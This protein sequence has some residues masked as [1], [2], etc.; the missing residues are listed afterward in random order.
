MKRILLD[1]YRRWWWMMA[2]ASVFHL[3]S[4]FHLF[5]QGKSEVHFPAVIFMGAIL[6]SFD[7]QR[8]SPA[9]ALLSLPVTMD[10][11]GRTWWLACVGI[12]GVWVTFLSLCAY[13]VASLVGTAKMPLDNALLFML[14]E[15]VLLGAQF[16]AFAEMPV[17]WPVTLWAQIKGV[18]A[19]GLWGGSM[20]GAMFF[21]QGLVWGNVKCDLLLIA[22][23]MS[24][25]GWWRSESLVQNRASVNR[26]GARK[27][28]AA[29]Q[30]RVD[31]GLGGVALLLKMLALRLALLWGATL[32]LLCILDRL[33]Q[34][35]GSLEAGKFFNLT[36]SALV[37][38]SGLVALF[39]FLMPLQMHLRYLRS[40]PLSPMKTA[41]IM[42]LPLVA[43]GFIAALLMAGGNALIGWGGDLSG[44]T[45]AVTAT[46]LLGL[47]VPLLLWRGMNTVPYMFMLFLGMGVMQAL[48]LSPVFLG[49]AVFSLWLGLALSAGITLTAVFLS[50]RLLRTSSKAYQPAVMPF[51]GLGMER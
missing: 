45:T 11:L 39:G 44:L 15:L 20:G 43:S 4:H 14:A 3:V 37:A 35:R 8:C 16:L 28:S 46:A 34:N 13:G 12:P 1:Y 29:R 27:A 25:A 31:A 5:V 42:V 24:I 18:A 41:M 26:A 48:A 49:H 19:G 9:R 40:L 7:L 38:S 30:Y 23:A 32:L 33:F 17:G 2:L 47:C 10:Q 50:Q 21:F 51:G 6:L 22:G 36:A